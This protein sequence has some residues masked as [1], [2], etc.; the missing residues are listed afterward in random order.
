MAGALDALAK[1]DRIGVGAP[2][3]EIYDGTK[4]CRIYGK[5]M[6]PIIPKD[7]LHVEAQKNEEATGSCGGNPWPHAESFVLFQVAGEL[8]PSWRGE[9]MEVSN[10]GDIKLGRNAGR[11]INHQ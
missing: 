1:P 3:E 9:N 11:R 8:L 7:H 6:E 2:G 5:K 10:L 4:S